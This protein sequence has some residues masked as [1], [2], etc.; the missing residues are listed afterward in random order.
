MSVIPKISISKP[1]KRSKDNLSFDVSTTAN[2][3]SIQPTMAR[4]MVPDQS[5]KVKVSSL[6][7]LASMPLP[8]FGRIHLRHYHA[9]VPFSS[10]Y[11][12]FTAMLSQQHYTTDT[13][14]SFIPTQV[15][16][17]DLRNVFLNIVRSYSYIS[18]VPEFDITNPVDFGSDGSAV[19]TALKAIVS[20]STD[21]GT[22]GHDS[23]NSVIVPIP[24]YSSDVDTGCFVFGSRVLRKS[25]SV[26]QTTA[27][28]D[29]LLPQDFGG[30][31]DASITSVGVDGADFVDYVNGYYICYKL[32]PFAKHLRRIVIGLGDQFTPVYSSNHYE[33]ILKYLAYYKTWFE[34]FR[35]N[36]EMSYQDTLCY[37][38]CKSWELPTLCKDNKCFTLPAGYYQNLYQF[39]VDLMYTNYYLPSDYF[40]M[41]TLSPQ[42]G[43]SDLNTN[44]SSFTG[45]SDV[46]SVINDTS[47]G[48]VSVSSADYPIIQKLASK[49]LTFVNKNTVVGRSIREYIKVHYGIFEDASPDSSGITR[50]GVSDVNVQISDVMSTAPNQD[51]YLGEYGGKGLGYN[52]SESFDYY[53]KEFGVWLTLSV[54]VPR[55][56]YYQGTLRENTYKDRFEWFTPE[57]DAL[58]Y[59]T[60]ERG[61]LKDDYSVICPDF[62]PSINYDSKAAFGFVPRYSELKVGRNIVNGDLS[63]GGM[64]SMRAYFFDR[65]IPDYRTIGY[66]EVPK[67]IELTAPA[68]VPSVVFDNFRRIDTTDH[69]GE[70]NRIFNVT[71]NI[72][73]HFIIHCVFD[74]A[75]LA[76]WKSLK[77]SF[78][79]FQEGESEI[80]V[81]HS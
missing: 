25:T 51:G 35:P 34:Y 68:Y 43:N 57:F 36:R 23:S 64:P 58:G 32:N 30:V 46:Q 9:F 14:V 65:R 70:Y 6:V 80:E 8:T 52:E 62:N 18:V 48:D 61:E 1:V 16:R 5:N 60:L 37:K 63:I 11:E 3:G 2:F 4:V 50:I 76:P 13:G 78:D 41:A 73:D 77:D 20:V 12:P 28:I 7:R 54:I 17:I 79:T 15:P 53:A 42:Y 22:F 66:I 33:H 75:T 38:I 27:Q 69:F 29:A 56:G 55:S 72:F 39:F 45:V 24:G 67:D 31:E 81:T 10:L 74:V 59:Q 26:L 71:S 40:S 47:F 49:L 21:Y 44:I 19:K